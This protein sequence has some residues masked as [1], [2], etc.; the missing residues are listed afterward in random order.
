V[1]ED[2][3]RYSCFLQCQ[4][5]GDCSNY[6]CEAPNAFPKFKECKT[7]PDETGNISLPMR[8]VGN[9]VHVVTPYG[10]FERNPQMYG[11]EVVNDELIVYPSDGS[12]GSFHCRG[13][14]PY[15]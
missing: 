9:S 13:S 6:C 12:G 15:H 3:L 7:R 5:C 11:F 8:G 4:F 2:S 14:D 10:R 1:Q